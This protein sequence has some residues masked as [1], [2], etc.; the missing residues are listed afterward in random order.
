MNAPQKLPPMISGRYK[1]LRVIAQGGM[2]TVYEVEHVRTGERLALKVLTWGVG[3]PRE[4]LERFKREA[5]A[6]AQI[7]SQYVVRV[8]DA[9][10]AAELGGAP[11]LVMELLEGTDLERATKQAPPDRA[12]AVEWLRQ[13]ASA[14]DK[15]HHMGI[16][17]RDLKPENLFLARQEEGP[18]IV[19]VLDFGIVKMADD[20]GGVTASGEIVGTPAYMAPEQAIAG[21]PIT[22]A[23]DRYTLGLLTHRLLT[24]ESYHG[25]DIIKI[26]SQLLYEKLRPPSERHP[27]LGAAFDA[28]FARACAR[29]PER[30]FGSATEQVDALAIAL[31]LR[32]AG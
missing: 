16:V 10:V 14:I 13:I 5:R 9:D 29:E 26:V 2:G 15:A 22:P 25:G 21:G 19:K 17:H 6:S 12:T 8:T 4:V 32:A 30:R 7:K 28:W 23:A 31:G 20:T 3:A 11:F 1:P 18:P 27:E 24:G